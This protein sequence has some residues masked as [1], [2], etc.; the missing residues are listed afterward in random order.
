MG[1]FF[2]MLSAL[3]AWLMSWKILQ[4]F[5]IISD[6]AVLSIKD[7]YKVIYI[8]VLLL[9]YFSEH[10]YKWLWYINFYTGVKFFRLQ[11]CFISPFGH[12]VKYLILFLLIFSYCF[13]SKIRVWYQWVVWILFFLL[14]F[15]I[16]PILITKRI[17]YSETNSI[18]KVMTSRRMS[19]NIDHS[20]NVISYKRNSASI[21][22]IQMIQSIKIYKNQIKIDCSIKCIIVLS[23]ICLHRHSHLGS[24]QIMYVG[25]SIFIRS[26]KI[27]LNHPFHNITTSKFHVAEIVKHWTSHFP[28]CFFHFRSKDK[29]DPLRKFQ[30]NQPPTEVK[31]GKSKFRFQYSLPYYKK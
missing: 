10:P 16:S 5:Y 28:F 7:T 31:N 19:I 27:W 1:F 17:Q 14:C 11:I 8:L 12:H 6:S 9:E 30:G 15:L 23:Q 22:F 4:A 25:R 2:A 3:F 18:S 13:L 24:P 20:F 21:S 26:W 29:M